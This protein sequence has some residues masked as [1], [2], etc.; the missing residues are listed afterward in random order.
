M[1]L[2]SIPLSR[3]VAETNTNRQMVI[4]FILNTSC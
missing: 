3:Q 1:L 4:V 2:T